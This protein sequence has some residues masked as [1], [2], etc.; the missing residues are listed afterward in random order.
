MTP[1]K[2]RD[3]G[4]GKNHRAPRKMLAARVSRGEGVCG[5]C[6]A[7]ILPDE[8]WVLDHEDGDRHRYRAIPTAHV[9]CNQLA[10]VRVRQ[11]NERRAKGLLPEPARSAQDAPQG[12]FRQWCAG[13]DVTG[14]ELMPQSIERWSRL[15]DKTPEEEQRLLG[16]D[17]ERY[18]RWKVDDEA[19]KR[20]QREVG[21]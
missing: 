13:V 9:R 10:A 5:R 8:P 1:T 18:L 7:S 19:Q 14:R 6:G 21:W 15:W 20:F 2:T 16:V 4:Y 3:R 12:A 11:R 17:T